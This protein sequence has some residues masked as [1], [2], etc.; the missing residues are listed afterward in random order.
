MS[1]AI[2]PRGLMPSRAAE[3]IGVSVGT[4]RR[5]SEAGRAPRPVRISTQRLV[6]LREDLDAYLDRLA[7]KAPASPS[8]PTLDPVAELD[9]LLGVTGEPALS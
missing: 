1:T 7:G 2:L 3:Y 4:L 9:A 6:Y 5:E 8:A